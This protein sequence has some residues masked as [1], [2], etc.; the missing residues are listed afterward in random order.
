M[1]A[2]GHNADRDCTVSAHHHGQAGRLHN[3]D[4]DGTVYNILF[5]YYFN[6]NY[7]YIISCRV[8]AITALYCRRARV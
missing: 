4:H 3:D 8:T 7:Y 2:D 5:Y 1:P 6:Y